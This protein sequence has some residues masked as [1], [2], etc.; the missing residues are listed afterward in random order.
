MLYA[1]LCYHDEALVNSW[2]KEEDD[3][4]LAKRAT[5]TDQLAA[6]GSSARRSA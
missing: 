1:L 4:L 3:A 6:N 5:V 2:T